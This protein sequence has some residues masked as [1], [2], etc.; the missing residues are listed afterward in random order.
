MQGDVCQ[1][2]PADIVYLFYSL[3]NPEKPIIIPSNRPDD[4]GKTH[5]SK[6]KETIFFVHG[7]GG[8]SSGPLVQKVRA[9][10]VKAKMDINIIGVD[11]RA[12]QLRNNKTNIYNCSKLFG[13]V[14]GNFLK[15]MTRKFGL[16]YSK[17]V[18]VGHSIAGTFCND[19]GYN[20]NSQAKAIVG[21]E[22]CSYKNTAKFVEVNSSYYYYTK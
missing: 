20:I 1:Y 3:Q 15:E 4:V 12:F 18:I 14:V 17:L 11:W 10:I 13:Q 2:V 5:F 16:D 7:S 22:T 8:N 9:A 6:S 19:I 21:L